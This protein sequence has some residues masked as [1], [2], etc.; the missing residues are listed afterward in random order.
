MNASSHAYVLKTKLG[1]ALNDNVNI[2]HFASQSILQQVA[3][4]SRA[5]AATKPSAFHSI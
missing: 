5:G 2:C 3:R 4:L 1:L